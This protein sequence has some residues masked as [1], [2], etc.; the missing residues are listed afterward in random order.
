MPSLVTD[1]HAAIW[2]F[3]KSSRLS[4]RARAAINNA[5]AGGDAVY[6]SSITLVEIVYLIEK[7]RL[8]SDAADTLEDGIQ[9]PGSRWILVPL[10]LS[11]AQAVSKIQRSLVPDMPDRIIAATALHLGLPLVTRDSK[12]NASGLKTIW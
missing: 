9:D 4:D 6:L 12:I 5:L 2:Y 11:V 1:T 8:P 7:G 3:L 10:D